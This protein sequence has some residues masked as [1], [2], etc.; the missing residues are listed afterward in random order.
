MGALTHSTL[1]HSLYDLKAESMNVPSSLMWAL[2][3]YEFEL[4]YKA[5][6][7]VKN[8][9]DM[10]GEGTIDHITESRWLKKFKLGCKN[11]NDLVK[12][13]RFKILDSEAIFLVEVNPVSC[14]RRVSGD[15]CFSVHCDSSLL[16]F[17][18]KHPKQPYFA[19]CCQ[20]I[21]KRLHHPFIKIVHNASSNE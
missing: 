1:L 8:M 12:S 4:G 19:S 14:T 7:A 21:A 17:L 15:L 16:R 3:I 10:K 9:C 11:L 5:A 2:M 18:Q 20:N 6:E 13:D